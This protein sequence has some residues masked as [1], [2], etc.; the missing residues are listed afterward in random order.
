M[1]SEYIIVNSSC[2]EC[3]K[4]G[5]L[6]LSPD[7][8]GDFHVKDYIKHR[9]NCSL[10]PKQPDHFRNR[11][12]WMKGEERGNALVGARN[13]AASG[14]MNKDG[15]G[16]II[17]KWRVETKTTE[18]NNFRLKEDI[19]NKLHEGALSAS[20]EP[21]LYIETCELK[22]VIVRSS[23]I[24]TSRS[25]V[26]IPAP[27]SLLL[28]TVVAVNLSK[29]ENGQIIAGWVGEPAVILKQNIDIEDLL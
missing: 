11:K 24:N 28:N 13:T 4:R 1:R 19:W 10:R 6:K 18:K 21:L 9:P 16:R 7:G 2:K 20:E 22:F 8:E 23:L 26:L 12:R 29:T 27:K 3:K 15:D 17:Q 14:A 25:D 5:K